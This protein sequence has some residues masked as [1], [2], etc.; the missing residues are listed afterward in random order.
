MSPRFPALSR[1]AVAA[2]ADRRVRAAACAVGVVAL[3]GATIRVV[4]APSSDFRLHRAWAERFLRGDFLY[5]DGAN[6][7]YLP[8]WALAHVPAALVPVGVAAGISFAAAVGLGAA[9]LAIVQRL[10]RE[11]VPTDRARRFWITAAVLL[12]TARFVL[13][14]LADAGANLILLGVVWIGLYAIVRGRWRL[15]SALVGLAAASKLTPGLFIAYFFYRRWYGTGLAALAFTA[16][17][18]LSPAAWLGRGSYVRHLAVWTANVGS[19]VTQPDPNVGV[20]GAESTANQALRPALGRLLAGPMLQLGVPKPAIA[21]LMWS[22]LAALLA[23]SA[24]GLNGDTRRTDA[25][26]LV[27]DWAA[28][29]MLMLLVSPITWRAHAVAVVPACWLLVG[30]WM[31]WATVP[32][33]VPIALGCLAVPNLLLT[34]ALAGDFVDAFVHRW[35]LFTW[36]FLALL[37]ATF[38]C[39]ALAGRSADP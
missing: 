13:R 14:D 4:L 20:L 9:V 30:A 12:L 26:L 33:S 25:P 24:W 21:V 36:A 39:R 16:L 17:F 37:V 31:I 5:Q 34:R 6:V 38:Q 35:S 28:L 22:I 32:L 23:V 11:T 2:G 27:W 19:G 29:S 1:V 8:F 7:P 18:S 3:A 15:G 10:S